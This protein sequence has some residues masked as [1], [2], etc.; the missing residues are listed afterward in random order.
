MNRVS[1]LERLHNIQETYGFISEGEIRK[2]SQE[3]K[4]PRARIYGVIRFYSMFYT[5]PVGKYIVRVCDS[6]SCHINDSEGIV[7]VVKD[8]LGIKNGE[9][10]EDKKFTLE[11]VECL[12]HCGEGPVMMVNDRIYTRV[13][14]NMALEILRD[15]V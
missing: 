4:M 1:F 13:S 7:E 3:Y 14:P 6:L 5:E 15:C 8:Y 9:T 12:G 10:T 2:L 11:V